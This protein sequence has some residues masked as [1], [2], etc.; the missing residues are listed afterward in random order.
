MIPQKKPTSQ[1]QITANTLN[2]EG[3]ST[4]PDQRTESSAP[5]PIRELGRYRLLKLLGEGGMGSVYLAHDTELDRKVA[6]KLP[7]MAKGKSKDQSDR[8][9]REARLAATLDHPN[10]CRIYD[11]GEIDG[12]L[13]LTMQFVEGKTLNEVIKAK[14]PI[15][16]RTAANLIRKIAK[17]VDAAHNI[18][19]IHRD[20]KPANV[21]IKKDRDF[22]IMDFGLARR[23]DR[24]DEQLTATGAVLGTPAYMSPEQLRGES[25]AIGPHSDVYSMGIMLYELLVGERPFQGTLPQIYAQILSTDSV[26]PSSVAPMVASELN[27]ICQRATHANLNVRYRSALEFSNALNEYL[28]P[29]SNHQ[30]AKKSPV[31]SIVT[32]RPAKEPVRKWLSNRQ[33]KM[34]A[35][36]GLLLTIACVVLYLVNQNAEPSSN[37]LQ[38]SIKNISEN[39]SIP[40]APDVSRNTSPA[41][42]SSPPP[43]AELPLSA[44]TVSIEPSMLIK[45]ESLPILLQGEYIGSIS[46]WGGNWGGQ[47]I[48]GKNS[49][50]ELSLMKGGLPGDGYEG[51]SPARK[52]QFLIDSN[53]DTKELSMLDFSVSI[54]NGSLDILDSGGNKLGSLSKVTRASTTLGTKPPANAVILFSS[55]GINN[56]EGSSVDETGLLLGGGRSKEQFGDFH[57]HIEFLV[58]FLPDKTGQSRANSGIFLPNGLEL[59]ILDSFGLPGDNR[60][61]G[62]IL[63]STNFG[64]QLAQPLQN[65][66]LPP[67]TWQTFDIDYTAAKFSSSGIREGNARISILHNGYSIHSN[68]EL[69]E[70]PSEKARSF[71]SI[72]LQMR[73]KVTFRN[74]W[75]VK[76]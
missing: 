76:K 29:V 38:A 21:M 52:I 26:A 64:Q 4:F 60:D 2:I 6:L 44:P 62:S 58:S 67:L 57:L 13:Y 53:G 1:E 30:Q 47:I 69:P 75:A 37:D 74:I 43:N 9:R 49:S 55:G 19:I 27:E 23:V 70:Q 11:S 5:K 40:S 33:L 36:I 63:T 42:T 54:K 66:S 56:F 35:G 45:Q 73:D 46:S 48:V 25:T 72:G 51:N 3:I 31:S 68:L 28:N 14:G 8:F 17:A 71:G 61:C 10:I 12:Q 16:P 7:H 20:L 65:V 41:P 24:D 34:G 59:Q 39:Q 50:Y 32:T 18:G 22:V 15:E